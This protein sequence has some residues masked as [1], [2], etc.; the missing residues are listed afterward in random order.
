M[1][2]CAPICISSD[3]SHPAQ[4]WIYVLGYINPPMH[5]QFWVRVDMQYEPLSPP[6]WR[7]HTNGWFRSVW[8]VLWASRL[9]R[10]P[11]LPLDARRMYTHFA[12]QNGREGEI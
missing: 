1:A 2:R 5:A 3:Q 12:A 9:P 11:T 6:N 8:R 10:E 4:H 7:T